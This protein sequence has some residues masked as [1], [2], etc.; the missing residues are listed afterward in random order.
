MSPANYEEFKRIAKVLKT[1]HLRQCGLS[2]AWTTRYHADV[3]L[4]EKLGCFVVSR[5][6]NK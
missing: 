1:Q 2:Y 4:S 3:L 5:V 6:L